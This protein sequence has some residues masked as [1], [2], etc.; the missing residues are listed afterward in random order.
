MEHS[1]VEVPHNCSERNIR[2]EAEIR[3]G[4][5]TTKSDKGAHRRNIMMTV[6]AITSLSRQIAFLC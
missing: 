5:R 2:R 6:L 3:E 4:G 1:E